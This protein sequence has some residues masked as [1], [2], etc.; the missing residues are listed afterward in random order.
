[1][2]LLSLSLFLRPFA[3]IKRLEI[4]LQGKRKGV[5]KMAHVPMDDTDELWRETKEKS[6]GSLE[7]TL[8][9]HKGKTNGIANELVE[10]MTVMAKK[11]DEKN[12][13]YPKSARELNQVLNENLS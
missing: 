8:Q 3:L 6:W 10:M 9:A 7:K 11:M 4:Y 1:M 5:S 13:P 2:I 12:A